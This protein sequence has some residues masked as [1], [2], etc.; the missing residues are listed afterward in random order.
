MDNLSPRCTYKCCDNEPSA[1]LTCALVS[2]KRLYGMLSDRKP[3]P[4]AGFTGTERH[5]LLKIV[6]VQ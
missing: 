6:I 5:H 2:A 3:E 1:Y 4:A